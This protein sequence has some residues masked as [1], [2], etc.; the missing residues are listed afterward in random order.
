MSTNIRHGYCIDLRGTDLLQVVSGLRD[1]LLHTYQDV[2][3]RQVV[4]LAT[5]YAD[6]YLR[7]ESL[8]LPDPLG[9]RRDQAPRLVSRYPLQDATQVLDWYK[10]YVDET[11]HR[12]PGE[13][14]S[15]DISFLHDDLQS[16]FAYALLFTERTEY[17]DAFERTQGVESF[18]YWNNVDRPDDIGEEEWNRRRAT[19]E[20][21]LPSHSTPETVGLTWSL[22]GKG[23]LP[24]E[25]FRSRPVAL[26]TYMLTRTARATVVAERRADEDLSAERESFDENGQRSY[27]EFIMHALLEEQS[28]RADLIATYARD[29]EPEL[30]ALD[31]ADLLD[32]EQRGST[33]SKTP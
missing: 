32:L 16:R 1:T 17:R 24:H 21:V 9:R 33:S 19:W 8:A 14:F 31:I 27:G 29:I 30:E 2:Y 3:Q 23:P 13:D 18:A 15:C 4:A 22:I 7:G 10:R 12:S 25:D 11:G 28:Q 6:A 26:T 20:R 5:V